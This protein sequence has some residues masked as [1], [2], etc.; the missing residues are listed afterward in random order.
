[1][2]RAESLLFLQTL[3][4]A[5]VLGHVSTLADE[6]LPQ[7]QNLGFMTDFCEHCS[8]PFF[9]EERNSSGQFGAQCCLNGNVMLNPLPNPP[10]ELRDLLSKAG[11][12]A[13]VPSILNN[14]AEVYF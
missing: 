14:T 12:E 10:Q 3:F 5:A 6:N 1:M 13:N 11:P 7:I 8:A 2:Y 4:C 9:P